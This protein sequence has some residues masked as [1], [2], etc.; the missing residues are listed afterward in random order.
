M[1]F[2]LYAIFPLGGAS[3]ISICEAAQTIDWIRADLQNVNVNQPTTVTIAVQ[4]ASDP[5]LIPTSINLVRYDSAGKATANL[6]RLYDDGTHGDT[7]AGDNVFISQIVF[8]EPA[9]TTILL[10]ASVGYKGLLKRILSDSLP[11]QVNFTPTQVISNVTNDLRTANIDGAMNGFTSASINQEVLSGMDAASL[12]R[13]ADYFQGAR[14]I[15]QTNNYRVYESYL[16]VN[17]EMRLLEF[18]V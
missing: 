12:N 4:V 2:Y 17:G 10:K 6:G 18:I 11:I 5:T 3:I 16:E 7:L 15:R 13:L 9:P 8:N 14:L 1:G